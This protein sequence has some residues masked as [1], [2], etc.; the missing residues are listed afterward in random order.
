MHDITHDDTG[1]ID[2]G[3]DIA[4][5]NSGEIYITG[6]TNGQLDGNTT[7]DTGAGDIFLTKFD[8]SRNKQWTRRR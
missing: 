7:E 4:I 5:D 8:S 6:Y 3:T 1:N 2:K